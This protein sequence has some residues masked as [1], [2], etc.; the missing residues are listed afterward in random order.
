[1]SED[2]L[3]PPSD[4]SLTEKV[5]FYIALAEYKAGA[6]IFK[7]LDNSNTSSEFVVPYYE[8]YMFD[9]SRLV[10]YHK[11]TNIKDLLKE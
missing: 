5:A 7:P 9:A 1:M 3:T 10:K 8:R 11:N 2:S 4:F 6:T